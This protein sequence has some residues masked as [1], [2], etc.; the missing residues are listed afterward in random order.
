MRATTRDL[1]VIAGVLAVV[2]ALAYA[3]PLFGGATL[4]GRDHL[5][6]TIPTKEMLAEALR[7]G[8][9]PEWW[10]AVDL[11]VPIAANPNHSVFYPPVWLLALLPMPWGIDFLLVLHIWFMGFGA[12]LLC[13]RLG[14]DR[15]GACVGGAA[16]MVSGIAST[17]V[18]LPVLTFAWAPWIALA[19]DRLA[20]APARRDVVR[21]C[22]L[23][24]GLTAA[25]LL[26][27][28]PSFVI[29]GSLLALG[30]VACRAPRRVPFVIVGFVVAAALAA[31]ALV[32]AFALLGESAR[33]NGV[34]GDTWSM[35]PL[36]IF[37]WLSPDALGDPMSSPA[38]LARGIADGASG[39]E[40]N[41]GWAISVY[42]SIPV[43]VLAVLGFLRAEPR[44]RRLGWLVLVFVLL[45]LGR[46]T[47]LYAAYRFVV[48]PERV[49]RYPEK[50]MA[51]ATLVLCVLA[52]LGFSA[53]A[54]RGL[55]RRSWQIVIATTIACCVVLSASLLLIPAL[56]HGAAGAA[57]VP[58]LD[59]AAGVEHARGQAMIAIVVV[60]AIAAT[61]YV[62]QRRTSL[63]PV[64]GV[65]LVG[66]LIGR[67][68]AASPTFDRDVLR[69]PP[70]IVAGLAKP[71]RIARPLHYLT[72][73]GDPLPAQA[74]TLYEGAVANSATRFGHSYIVGYDQGHTARFERWRDT[75][76]ANPARYGA[77]VEIIL[78]ER[79]D[80]RPA[81]ASDTPFGPHA[82]IATANARP[83][84]FVTLASKNGAD[85]MTSAEPIVP[86]AVTSPRP[87]HVELVCD[88]P[89]GGHAVLLDAWAAGWNARVD[90]ADVAIEPCD[91]VVRAVRVPP[92]RHTISFNYATPGLRTGT[93][94]TAIAWLGLLAAFVILRKQVPS[95]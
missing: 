28:D 1:V 10:D 64:A 71:T 11:G 63:T 66:H 34:S 62:G 24:A 90:G 18:H 22:L 86:C 74:R 67:T 5:T 57:I 45:A 26:A 7:D 94:V 6:H 81:L 68:W 13:R 47:P 29:A 33:A 20:H 85:L 79:L 44:I 25:A 56:A 21:E 3:A 88:S 73:P 2:A 12:A 38:Y 41:P 42:I 89:A 69:R 82:L 35:H 15:T 75:V 32:P 83:R 36:R 46:F 61:V 80:G 37:E 55:T 77:E 52:G 17:L 93:I 91:L 48:L 51:G 31:I 49:V 78:D 70:L 84:A 23:L 8:R 59:V 19:A 58:A 43:I 54:A 14:A 30:L 60:L 87:E 50:Y 40:L 92:G 72:R 4:I 65:I 76:G 9:I 16:F 53:L 39:T 27:G 95:R